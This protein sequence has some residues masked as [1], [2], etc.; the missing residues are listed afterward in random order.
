MGLA[1]GNKVAENCIGLNCGIE[2]TAASGTVWFL[3]LVIQA[4][5]LNMSQ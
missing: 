1:W 3:G 5:Q 4:S 2:K